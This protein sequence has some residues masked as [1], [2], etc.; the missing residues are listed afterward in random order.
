MVEDRDPNITDIYLAIKGIIGYNMGDSFVPHKTN[1]VEE[2]AILNGAVKAGITV[3]LSTNWEVG[4]RFAMVFEDID[5]SGN[6]TCTDEKSLTPDEYLEILLAI[7]NE[8][9]PRNL[10]EENNGDLEY[11][12]EVYEKA[13]CYQNEDD[14]NAATTD[15]SE[16]K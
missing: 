9:I 11:N 3:S 8:W 10:F 1:I 7:R 16:R 12:E 4:H 14:V 13:L 5:E 15:K 2:V 6:V